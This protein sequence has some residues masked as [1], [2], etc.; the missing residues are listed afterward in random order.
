MKYG[1]AL[2]IA[3]LLPL[4]QAHAQHVFRCGDGSTTTYSDRPCGDTR[5]EQVV[6]ARPNSLDTIKER[7]HTERSQYRQDRDQ[8]Y[9]VQ[10]HQRQNAANQQRNDARGAERE[11]KELLRDATTVMPGAHGLTASQR[12]AARRLNEVN[13]GRPMPPPAMQAEPQRP[14]HATGHSPQTPGQIV[15]CDPAGC[16]DTNG[17]RL[18]KAAGGNF[19][20]SD[21]KFCTRAGPNVICH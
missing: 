2:T 1:A 16:W 8:Q 9:W 11:R 19:H 14:Q 21:G 20:R 10:E 17:K 4:S 15:N 5:R 3:L 13:K 6:N 18:N 7:E 12:D